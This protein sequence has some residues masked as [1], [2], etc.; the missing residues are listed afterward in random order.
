MIQPKQMRRPNLESLKD[1]LYQITDGINC[2]VD[3]MD[4]EKGFLACFGDL[5]M[6][7]KDFQ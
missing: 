5:I 3:L 2:Q 6:S 1:L 4:V 7:W